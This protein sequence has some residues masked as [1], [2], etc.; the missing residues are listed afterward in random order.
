MFNKKTYLDRRNKLKEIIKSGI[1]LLAGNE[2]SP[3]EAFAHTYPFRQDSSFLYYSGINKIPSLFL[4]IDIDNDKEILFGND[5]SLE[6]QIWTG[7]ISTLAEISEKVGINHVNST[8]LLS[9]YLEKSISEKRKIHYLPTCRSELMVK[10]GIMLNIAAHCINKNASAELISAIISQR[11][12]KTDEE[13]TEIESALKISSEIF[14]MLLKEIRPG[15]IE[16]ELLAKCEYT[17]ISR[18]TTASFPHI[19]TINGRILHNWST[20]N[21]SVLKENDLLLI[22]SGVMSRS[23]YASDITRTYPVSEK[24]TEK[25]KNIYNIVLNGQLTAIKNMKPG[26]FYKDIHLQT[27]KTIAEGLKNIG[28]MKGNITDAVEAGAHALFYPH[29]LGHMLGMD[30]HDMEI[31]GEDNVGY[32]SEIKRSTQ[33]GLAFLRLAKR[34]KKGFVV[35]VEPGIYFIPE[36]IDTWKAENKHCEFINYSEVEKYR[37]FEGIRI[38]DDVLVTENGCRVL[39]DPIPKFVNEIETAKRS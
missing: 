29:G 23:G 28:L 7:K 21:D 33:F 14:S 24:F 12:C 39:G 3:I 16:R 38:E 17:L 25:Q 5:V 4:L 20:Y 6:D 15:Q 19:L 8:S 10:L 34:L 36:L 22:D 32:D 30:V 31:L 18:G 27:A 1:I 35:T 26:V 13:I 11:E 9:T 2:K 37:D